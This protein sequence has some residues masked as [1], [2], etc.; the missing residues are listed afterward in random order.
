M[1]R[2]AFF[3]RGL[4]GLRDSAAKRVPEPV[5]KTI[6]YSLLDITVLTDD[7]ERADALCAELIEPHCD[8]R[9]LRL[10]GTQLT[11]IFPGGVLLLENGRRARLADGVSLLYAGLRQLAAEMQ[12]AQMQTNPTLLRYANATPPFSRSVEVWHRDALVLALPLNEA[13][14]FTCEGTLGTVTFEVRDGRCALVEAPCTHGI[15]M[16][17]PPIVA[18]GERISC[19]PSEIF[20]VIGTMLK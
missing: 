5:R 16:A 19:L 18:P 15:C 4:T 17:Q 7:P 13:G 10:R 9:L 2:R 12:L 3:K 11:G 14:T 6:G 1:D 8:A 20:A